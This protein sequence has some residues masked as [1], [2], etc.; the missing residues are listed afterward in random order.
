MVRFVSEGQ[1]SGGQFNK[2]SSNSGREF[3]IQFGSSWEMMSSST[4]NPLNNIH[5]WPQ[6]AAK[7]YQETRAKIKVKGIIC[8]SSL[9]TQFHASKPCTSV[10]ACNQVCVC[11]QVCR[12]MILDCS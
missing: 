7:T 3:Y 6:L 1:I 2:D 12:R 5:D 11:P 10:C 8:S 4:W 9:L